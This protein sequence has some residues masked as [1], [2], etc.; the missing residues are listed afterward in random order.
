MHMHPYTLP[1]L[2]PLVALVAPQESVEA[3]I[4]R[5]REALAAGKLTEAQAAFDAADAAERGAPRTRVWVV[6]GWI[7]AGKFDEALSATDELKAAKAPA[8]DLDYLYGLG[9][10]GMAKAAIASNGGGAFTQSQL[11]DSLACLQR[12]TKA[13]SARYSDAWLPLAESAWYAQDL[14]TARAASRAG[15]STTRA[16]CSAG[17]ARR[18]ARPG[19]SPSATGPTSRC[20]RRMTCAC[21]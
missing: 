10:L 20:G 7:A 18:P 12:A 11:E 21:R 5:G 6:R 17:S 15:R 14:T 16:A 8:A 13:D 9:F 19:R 2:L 3:L 4:K 1:S